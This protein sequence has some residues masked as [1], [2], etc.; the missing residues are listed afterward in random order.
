MA[1]RPGLWTGLGHAPLFSQQ[2]GPELYQVLVPAERRD[3]KFY[4]G[5][6]KFDALKVG[7]RTEQ[8]YG[9][10]LMDTTISGNRN[11]ATNSA[12]LRWKSLNWR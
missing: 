9:A 8:F 11:S 4:L 6:K 7:Y 1:T 5:T 10:F 2:L 12:I 3:K